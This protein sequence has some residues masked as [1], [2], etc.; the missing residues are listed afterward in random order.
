[1][2][3]LRKPIVKAFLV[4]MALLA[5]KVGYSQLNGSG[6]PTLSDAAKTSLSALVR[7]SKNI[8]PSP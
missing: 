8:S 2:E 5:A 6:D 7:W 4:A 1:M 3:T